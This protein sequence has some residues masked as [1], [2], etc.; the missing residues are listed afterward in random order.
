MSD[1]RTFPITDSQVASLTAELS[2]HGLSA[3]LRSNGESV[4]GKWD[5]SWTRTP[6]SI[7]I[8]VKSHPF[9]EE[10]IFWGKVQSALA[11]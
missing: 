6:T 1:A 5:I 11:G 4:Q 3:D 7:T 8:Q 9:A 2:Q 10:G